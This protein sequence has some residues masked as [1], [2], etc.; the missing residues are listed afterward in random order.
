MQANTGQSQNNGQGNNQ[1]GQKSSLSWSQPSTPSSAA[2]SSSVP[3]VVSTPPRSTPVANTAAMEEKSYTGTYIGIFVGGIIIGALIG[4]AITSS[5][6]GGGST[7]TS[8]ASSTMMMATSSA[9]ATNTGSTSANLSDSTADTSGAFAVNSPQVAGFAVAVSNV[10]VS[11]P[12]WVVVYEDNAGKVGNALGAELFLPQSEGTAQDGTVQLLRATL[13]GQNYFAGEALDNGDKTF[14]LT[15][16]KPVVNA[17]GNQIL[18]L[19][20]AH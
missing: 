14:S 12:T 16:D 7:S 15:N 8:T 6:N 18:V 4:W 1:A 3:P 2:P 13:P 11:Q 19:F 17:E 20:V 5:H 9:S 10:M